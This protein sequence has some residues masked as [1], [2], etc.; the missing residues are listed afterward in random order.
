MR[1][2]IPG[3][4][5]V[6]ALLLA[7]CASPPKVTETATTTQLAFAPERP[8]PAIEMSPQLVMLRPDRIPQIAGGLAGRTIRVSRI[9]DITLGPKEVVLTFDDGPVPGNTERILE[10]L[11]DFG[12]KATF[13][14]VG[15]MAR[16]YPGI[17][18][19][20]AARGHSIGSH[21][22][23]HPN[24]A[25]MS[26]GAALTEINAGRRSVEAALTPMKPAPFF[27]FPYLASTN[28]LR[29]SLAAQGIVVID[30]DIDSKDYFKVGPTVVRAQ[31]MSRVA[32]QGSGIILL[33]DLHARTAAML[34]G[35]LSDLKARGYKVVH[36]APGTPGDDVLMASVE[37]E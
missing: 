35:L 18:R 8:A 1:K 27:R 16:A 26:H 9:S 13:L 23:N 4:G 33:H 12:V 7:G 36:L 17:A 21:T 6:M 3:L 10:T 29:N 28:A 11:D 24:L 14:M 31:T 37:A 20:V 22:Q 34:P 5:A 30:V 15:Q 19:K 2:W 32:R 25:A